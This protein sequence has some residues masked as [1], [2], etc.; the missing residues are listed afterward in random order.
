[1]MAFCQCESQL[2]HHDDQPCHALPEMT[3]PAPVMYLN[4]SPM[5]DICIAGYVRAGYG[6]NGSLHWTEIDTINQGG[7]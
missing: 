1:M 3:R 6:F 5:C 7:G 4:G 2:C